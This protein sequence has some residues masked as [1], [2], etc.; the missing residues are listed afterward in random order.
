MHGCDLVTEIKVA[1]SFFIP[2][3]RAFGKH[4]R[5]NY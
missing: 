2:T 5:R 4:W 3:S 1:V